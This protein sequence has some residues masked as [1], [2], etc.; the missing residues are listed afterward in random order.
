M[1]ST[2]AWNL[3]QTLHRYNFCVT[4]LLQHIASITALTVDETLCPPPQ[5]NRLL[6]P[7]LPIFIYQYTA[8]TPFSPPFHLI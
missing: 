6:T 7:L 1:N 8:W 3:S 4:I 2:V 5:K